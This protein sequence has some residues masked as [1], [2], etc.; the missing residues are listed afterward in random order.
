[1]K[2]IIV[3]G[4]LLVISLSSQAQLPQLRFENISSSNG[5]SGNEVTCFFQDKEGFL[6]IGTK[7]GLNRYDGMRFENYFH[8]LNN[9]HSISGNEIVDIK[10]DRDGIIWIATK[11]GGLTRYDPQQ[12]ANNRFRQFTHDPADK[13][14]IATNRLNCLFDFDGSYLLIGAEMPPGIFLNKK[15]FKFSYWN[16]DRP[17]NPA[18][19]S[20]T[21]IGSDWICHIEPLN[22]RYFLVSK[23]FYEWVRPVE[24]KTGRMVG[25][26]K[27]APSPIAFIV[28][29]FITD[30][31]RIWLASW[32]PGLYY[33]ELIFDDSIYVSRQVQHLFLNIPVIV[34]D[35]VCFNK[36]F[37]LLATENDGLYLVNK[38][39]KQ[40][41]KIKHQSDQ[42]FSLASNEVNC[43]FKDRS[44]IWWIGTNNGI[45]KYNPMAWQ[46]NAFEFTDEAH[47]PKT[48][49]SI[50]EDKNK[51][52]RV[53]TSEGIYKKTIED[54]SFHS[55]TFN[56]KGRLIE[57]TF[58][59]KDR[60]DDFIMGTE[61]SFFG[62]DPAHER[63]DSF[64]IPYNDS[65]YYSPYECKI[66]QVRSFAEDVL[67]DMPVY[68]F[69]VLGWGAGCYNRVDHSYTMFFNL[70]KPGNI[71]NNLARQIVI[72]KQRNVWVASAGGL[73][74]WRRN[75]SLL[76]EFDSF[77]HVPNDP[78]SI[79]GDD[80]TALYL[81]SSDHLWITTNGGGLNQ[82]NGTAFTHYS[83]P[84]SSGQFLYGI[85]PDSK[86]RFWMPSQNGF[87][88]F[89]PGRSEWKHA[90]LPSSNYQLK[91]PTQLTKLSNGAF[92]YGAENF[93][94]TFHPDSFVFEDAYPKIYLTGFDVFNENFLS[95]IKHA[96]I[97]LP[98]NKN[99]FSFSFSALELSQPG[100]IR[101][102]YQM[103]GLDTNWYETERLGKASFTSMPPGDY[104]FLARV[105]NAE[106]DW[107]EPVSL[108]QVTILHPFWE[109]WWFFLLVAA[110]F[111]GLIW[112]YFYYR[113]VQRTKIENLRNRIAHDLHDEIGSTLGSISFYSE[114]SVRQLMQGKSDKALDILERI[115][116]NS[117]LMIEHMSDIV[118]SVSA[119][120]DTMEKIILRMKRFAEDQCHSNEIRVYFSCSND[121]MKLNLGMA[122]R[123]N[124]FLIFKE[125]VYNSVKHSGCE[126]LH[127][128]LNLKNGKP[129]LMIKDNGSGFNH[130]Q[131]E[132]Y[133][134]NGLPGMKQRANEMNAMLE[135]ISV[136]NNGTM[137][138]LYW[139]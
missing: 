90:N 76:N 4:S 80:V 57:P 30:E 99:F 131:P 71:Q 35:V 135:V 129:E 62:Y 117:R 130:Q 1:M 16:N 110:T 58:I 42:Q 88:I 115:G 13:S 114:A 47:R 37:L 120:N 127:I 27:K 92:C 132:S 21:A 72:D 64:L 36:E 9:R 94:I 43:I 124:F 39:T 100:A 41:E 50:Y 17:I 22:D 79:S 14:S 48:V 119:A 125:A 81:D 107:S 65:V 77:L 126:E 69:A 96:S 6:W 67:S 52:L 59:V 78:S 136:G 5:L 46:F 134:G 56:F 139:N 121:V 2:R 15:T 75:D 111:A 32:K 7:Q 108:L 89:F 98:Y 29:K 8:D 137:I 128:T 82:L 106:G 86:G 118:W 85:I 104:S 60:E 23:L 63:I 95:Q 34:K 31:N 74:R 10:Q 19:A 70:N 11:D 61:H 84:S 26:F 54:P 38:L 12:P 25:D 40:V 45:S 18:V 53:C 28:P 91:M 97:Q 101:F 93:V 20:D 133:N 112:L 116:S 83:P 123:K 66:Y 122:E 51:T 49:F 102:S 138:H 3:S 24:R 44:G 87:E 109:Q 33:Q 55:I 113:Q 103:N 68:W 105:T 73:Y